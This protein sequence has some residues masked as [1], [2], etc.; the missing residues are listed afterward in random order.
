MDNIRWRF[1][2][3]G[4]G[5]TSGLN[6]GD[7]ETFS[8]NP[9]RSLAREI[10]Q[11]TID[12]KIKE[13]EDSAHLDFQLFEIDNIDIPGYYELLNE[14][15]NCKDYWNDFG[16][17]KTVNELEKIEKQLKKDKILC[18]R[19]SDFNTTG[20]VGVK[21]NQSSA[22][23]NLVH[24]SG[25][26][27]KNSTSGGSK[28]IG[29]YATFINSYFRTVFYSTNTI[30]GE[31]GYEGKCILCSGKIPGK[32]EITQGKGYYGMTNLNEAV[33]QEL[34]LDKNFKRSES[35]FGTDIY[36]L[37][38]RNE[39]NWQKEIINQ[40]L[41]SFM[42]AIVNGGLTIRIGNININKD[43]LKDIVYNNEII[44]NKSDKANIISQY[45]LLTQKEDIYNKV[46]SV[47]DLGEVHLYLK[48]FDKNEAEYAL[49]KCIMIRYPYMRITDKKIGVIQ[50]ISA[51]CIIPDNK[52]NEQLRAIENPEHTKWSFERIDNIDI[53]N[54]FKK[55]INKMYK[56]IETAIS[57][58]LLKDVKSVTELE[59]AAEHIQM[60]EQVGDGDKGS[61]KIEGPVNLI[62]SYR[63]KQSKKGAIEDEY[64]EGVAPDI[65]YE[66]EEGK[67]T[68]Y[69]PNIENNTPSHDYQINPNVIGV[70]DN[71]GNVIYK[72]QELRGMIFRFC[73]V[74]KKE[75]KYAIFFKSDYDEKDVQLVITP[76]DD[77]NH[78]IK[79]SINN[80][81]VNGVAA[82]TKIN[83]T[84]NLDI[85][86]NK[87]FAVMFNT[88]QNELFTCGVKCYAYKK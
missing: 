81:Y 66:L 83:N 58:Y 76:V 42:A 26:S 30:E 20:L 36:I 79:L 68:I 29:K 56:D 87:I 59:G 41:D 24:G 64:G 3:N 7:L 46:I 69:N 27:E 35:E 4:G 38:F 13:N 37:G 62:E 70:V 18:L 1:P 75:N 47:D 77:T 63:P 23:F 53:R 82:N 5:E 88:D 28:G 9:I 31:K 67:E 55:R 61:K 60:S 71:N 21:R 22:W 17:S 57:E 52:L 85:E 48:V 12:A 16:S 14:I 78:D 19:I 51:L 6:I 40:I 84:I 44:S 11:N 33:D 49:N 50:K 34:F 74:N 15:Q 86:K 32:N 54:E 10:A 39:K 8:D 45:I 43:T 65:G 2:T 73:S 72:R 25:I 80:C